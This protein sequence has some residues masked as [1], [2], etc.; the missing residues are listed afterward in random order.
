MSFAW[1]TEENNET[2]IQDGQ[3]PGR[4]YNRASPERNPKVR[5]FE[6]KCSTGGE[7]KE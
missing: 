6:P 4:H 3:Y 5:P 1:R 7:R 2:L